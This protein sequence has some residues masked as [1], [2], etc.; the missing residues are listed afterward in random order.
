[1]PTSLLAQSV[2][3]CLQFQIPGF[4]PWVG[5]IPSEEGNGN[6]LQYSCLENYMNR[7]A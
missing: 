6:L 2:W 4:D 3:F 5:K 7:G 1:M